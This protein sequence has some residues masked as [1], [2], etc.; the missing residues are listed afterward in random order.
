MDMTDFPT[1]LF[2]EDITCP[3]QSASMLYMYQYS[4]PYSGPRVYPFTIL[5]VNNGHFPVWDPTRFVH[6]GLLY[7]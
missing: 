4:K 6:H 3:S 2:D 7:T 5:T 1:C